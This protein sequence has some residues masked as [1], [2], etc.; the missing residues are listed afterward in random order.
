M[1][2]GAMFSIGAVIFLAGCLFT[3][4]IVLVL[5]SR[6]TGPPP[7]LRNPF[8]RAA[9]PQPVAVTVQVEAP[10]PAPIPV[11]HP[12]AQQQLVAV[13]AGELA[14]LVTAVQTAPQLTATGAGNQ[15]DDRDRPL[16]LDR[17][18]S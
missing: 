6:K 16:L 5:T 12:T 10:Q 15:A 8:T 3:A 4:F 1:T 7:L 17:A 13:P 11:A 9:A 2:A 14:A 18:P